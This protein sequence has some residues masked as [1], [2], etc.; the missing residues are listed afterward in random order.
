MG[1]PERF[2][3]GRQAPFMDGEL[4][5]PTSAVLIPGA[6]VSRSMQIPTAPGTMGIPFRCRCHHRHHGRKQERRATRIS[7]GGCVCSKNGVYRRRFTASTASP[8]LARIQARGLAAARPLPERG[9]PRTSSTSSASFG[10][11]CAASVRPR[12]TSARREPSGSP[13]RRGPC[14]A[15]SRG[16]LQSLTL[17]NSKSSEGKHAPK[18]WRTFYAPRFLVI[19]D[20]MRIV[21]RRPRSLWPSVSL[22]GTSRRHTGTPSCARTGYNV[23]T[24]FAA[25]PRWASSPPGVPSQRP[26]GSFRQ[27]EKRRHPDGRRRPSYHSSA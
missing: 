26:S 8:L 10:P 15:R 9:R 21:S 2:P 18:T 17:E 14:T 19:F 20:I 22:T 11:R 24:S 3:G 12:T 7:V 23:W 5:G 6:R 16:A 27:K 1:L 25:L 13:S 4:R